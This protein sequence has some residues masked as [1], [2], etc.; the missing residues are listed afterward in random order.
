MNVRR[1]KIGFVASIICAVVITPL[2]VAAGVCL[3]SDRQ[4][5]LVSAIAAA[6]LLPFFVAFERGDNTVRELVAL[7]VMTAISVVGRLVFAPIPGFKP[8]AAVTI[9]TGV[10][11]GA[12]AG[13]VTGALSAL[14]SNIFYGQGPWT[15]FQMLAWGLGGFLSGLIFFNKKLGKATLPLLVVVGFFAGVLYSAI[16]DVWSAVS[17]TGEFVW[18]AYLA[19]LTTSL[20]F[21]IEYAVSN[22]IFLLV[23]YK[24]MDRRLTRVK[25]KFGVFGGGNNVPEIVT[26]NF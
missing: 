17:M 4:Y 2:F 14:I 18:Q 5:L 19:A 16:M 22:V 23:L 1:K 21:T 25:L 9:I 26:E 15:P 10:Y 3:L 11:F 13:F 12:E 20:P 8:V 6:A 24:P 7:A